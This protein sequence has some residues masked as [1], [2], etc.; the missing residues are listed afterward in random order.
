MLLEGD[1]VQRLRLFGE[2]SCELVRTI[3]QSFGIKLTEDDLIQAETIGALASIVF[4]KLE[5]PISPQCLSSV[6]FYKLRRAFGELFDVPRAKIA[7]YTS[8]QELMPWKSRKTQWRRVQDR[9]NCA[10]PQLRWPLSLVVM[11]LLLT[12]LAAY[13]LLG[14]SMLTALGAASGVVGII[15]FISVLVLLAVILSPLG[16]EFPRSCDTFGDLVKLALARNYGKIASRYGMSS[17]E[18]SVQSLLLQL[19]AAEV[20]ADVDELSSDTRFTEGLR[21]Y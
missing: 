13:L 19:I 11:W 16:R 9:L 17:Q 5:H 12:A 20:S 4:A 7:P 8:L 2:D 10:L 6:M 15:T 3:E 21:I 14:L 18:E 1:K